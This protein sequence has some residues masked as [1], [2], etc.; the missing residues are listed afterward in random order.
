MCG[1]PRCSAWAVKGAAATVQATWGNHA[2]GRRRRQG[3]RRGERWGRQGRQLFR[4]ACA[5]A[6]PL[7]PYPCHPPAPSPRPPPPPPPPLC[8][9]F[10]SFLPSGLLPL[11]SSPPPGAA[12]VRATAWSATA[13]RLPPSAPLALPAV[14]TPPGGLCCSPTKTVGSA[15]ALGF[16]VAPPPHLLGACCLPPWLAAA[17]RDQGGG[18][19]APGPRPRLR[20][21]PPPPRPAC[22]TQKTRPRPLPP[23]LCRTPLPYRRRYFLC[24]VPLPLPPLLLLLLLRSGLALGR[25]G[26]TGCFLCRPEP[27]QRNWP[28]NPAHPPHPPCH[29]RRPCRARRGGCVWVCGWSAGCGP[30]DPCWGRG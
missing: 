23:A 19:V 2:G 25:M 1:V 29:S 22:L 21:P 11:H 3:A 13:H 16:A 10:S 17:Y 4:A 5:A 12:R 26:H 7:C 6:W 28:Q 18:D 8:F 15:A 30:G 24:A 9:P 20:R 14:P 27:A